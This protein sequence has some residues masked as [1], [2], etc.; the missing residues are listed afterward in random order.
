M[1]HTLYH[2]NNLYIMKLNLHSSINKY[3]FPVQVLTN[4]L[5]KAAKSLECFSLMFSKVDLFSQQLIR[6]I[7]NDE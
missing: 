7:I 4:I 6:I 2:M 3:I 5:K 1:I